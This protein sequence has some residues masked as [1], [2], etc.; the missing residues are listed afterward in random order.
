MLC[1]V[2]FDFVMTVSKFIPRSVSV[3]VSVPV[4]VFVVF[5]CVPL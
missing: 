5:L 4:S 3:S 1:D 2:M